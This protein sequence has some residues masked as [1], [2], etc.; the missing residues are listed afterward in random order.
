MKITRISLTPTQRRLLHAL[1]DLHGMTNKPIKANE[2]A[3]KLNKHPGSIRNSAQILT[4]LGLIEG[5]HGPGG[6]YMPTS[7]AY[8]F[9]NAPVIQVV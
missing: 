2:L 4:S 6:G 7:E 8:K 3:T 9:E 5:F 1:I